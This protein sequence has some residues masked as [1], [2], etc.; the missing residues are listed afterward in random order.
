MQPRK[1]Q[2][3]RRSGNEHVGGDQG[4]CEVG[5][6]GQGC[7]ELDIDVIGD[8]QLLK[9][10]GLRFFVVGKCQDNLEDNAARVAD[11]CQ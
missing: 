8:Q 6:V 2:W 1:V 3:A 4:S 7:R 9:F 5:Q 10:T 11:S